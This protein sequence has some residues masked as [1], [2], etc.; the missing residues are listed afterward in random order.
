MNTHHL[1]QTTDL[2]LFAAI[3]AEIA[4]TG[5]A[6]NINQAPAAAIVSGF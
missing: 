3:F 2:S 1:G 4:L 6:G 5:H